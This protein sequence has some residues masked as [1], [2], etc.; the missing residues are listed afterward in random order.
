MQQADGR[1]RGLAAELRRDFGR[2][3]AFSTVA[4]GVIAGVVT[5]GFAVSYAALIFRGDLSSHLAVGMGGALVG[6]LAVGVAGALGSPVRGL[7]AGV[8]DATS[9]VLGIA[10]AAMVVDVAA[11]DVVPSVVALVA[12][13]SLTTGVILYLLGRFN[14]GGLARFLP[15]TLVGGFLA[16]TGVVII[17]GGL[18]ILRGGAS[19]GVTT[20]T[21][22]AVWIPG[23]VVAVVLFALH[24]LTRMTL[25]FP[26]GMAGVFVA[27]H[28][29][30]L[31]AGIGHSEAIDRGWLLGSGDQVAWSPALVVDSLGADWA[32]VLPQ[33]GALATV[34]ALAAVSLLLYSQSLEA[35]L[36][37]D[38]DLDRELMVA[39]AGNVVAGLAGGP[40]GYTYSADTVLL[41]R[42]GAGRRG[43]ALVA[44]GVVAAA[45][46]AGPSLLTWIPRGVVGGLLLYVGI[47][48]V[49]EWLW[50]ARDRLTPVDQA[51]ILRVVL[52]VAFIGL[53]TGL[54]TGLVLAVITFVVRYSRIGVV[55]RVLH[56]DEVPVSIER[57]SAEM[58]LIE[59]PGPSTMVLELNGYLFFGTAHFL[60]EAV[61]ERLAEPEPPLRLALFDL[62]GVTGVDASALGSIDRLIR[63]GREHA[64]TTI[65]A[66]SLVGSERIWSRGSEGR[67]RL[68]DEFDQAVKWCQDEILRAAGAAAEDD[69]LHSLTALLSEEVAPADAQRAVALFDRME[70]ESGN[71]II[72]QGE[73]SPGLFYLESGRLTVLLERA[74]ETDVKL[75]TMRPGTVVGEMSLY[76]TLPASANV[77]ADVPSVVM[78]ITADRFSELQGAVPAAAAWLHWFVARTLAARVDHANKTIRALRR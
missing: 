6:T 12:L 44:A 30:F 75:R 58:E 23:A 37:H 36:R 63:Y 35:A 4:G 1:I 57:P 51:V 55:E 2:S 62:E 59:Q 72:E 31:A 48:L 47:T 65:L 10:A 68:S 13:S 74:G 15:Y 20:A 45:L 19:G 69:A 26:I 24:R 22:W 41:Y 66:G 49:I 43:A 70:L 21:L 18:S 9:A 16:A 39:G 78:R 14:F 67:V 60:V 73:A 27:L 42:L 54:V 17:Q 3:A 46:I 76:R 29:G 11:P 34:V 25:T 33:A 32:A 56:I 71:R 38:I 28:L 40:P 61:Q 53:V 64:F 5:T 7:M 8:Q 52:G 77:R 50:D